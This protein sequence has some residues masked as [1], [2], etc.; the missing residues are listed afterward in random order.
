MSERSATPTPSDSGRTSPVPSDDGK[1]KATASAARKSPTPSINLNVP[2]QTDGVATEQLR[3]RSPSPINTD[4]AKPDTRIL[5][6]ASPTG[7]ST[8]LLLKVRS[9]MS[10]YKILEHMCMEIH[11]DNLTLATVEEF[12]Q[13]ADS[14]HKLFMKDHSYFEV[15]WPKDHL[16]HEYYADDIHANEAFLFMKIKTKLAALRE[17]ILAAQ[18]TTDSSTDN[19]P[20]CAN[21][22]PD[23]ALPIF[24]GDVKEWPAFKELFTALVLNNN[25]IS[26]LQKLHYLR[27]YVRG[28]AAHFITSLSLQPIS[29]KISMDLLTD[30]YENRHVL[31]QTHLDKILKFAPLTSATAENL[32]GLHD[33]VMEVH[34]ALSTLDT[35]E[36]LGEYWL[37]ALAAQHLDRG[38][39]V[40]WETA[41]GAS[42]EYPTLKGFLS[43]VANC[44]RSKSSVERI[45]DKPA[46]STAVRSQPSRSSYNTTVARTASSTA[47]TTSATTKATPCDYC[48]EDHYIAY[49]P[50]FLD[51][52][53]DARKK[54]VILNRLCFNCLGRHS[55]RDCKTSNSCK[56]CGVRHHTLLH[57]SKYM[58]NLPQ[59]SDNRQSK[60][61]SSAAAS[62]K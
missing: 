39:R 52:D 18:K 11:N 56:N 14:T 3:S 38:T 60:P 20:T 22:L 40:A 34:H 47:P 16:D 13:Q 46:T 9:Q 15:T 42:K 8:E 2:A 27:S 51:L 21:K 55:S 7:L 17:T 23:I 26:D 49:C 29:L 53:V 32:I 4:A 54:R 5:R 1:G 6:S 58:E 30:R 41:T 25:S 36:K 62:N 12:K 48:H 35:K 19:A 45:K 10:R 57:G 28:S 43:F 31:I 61:S 59:K 50:G 33:T 24:T 44:S 37:V